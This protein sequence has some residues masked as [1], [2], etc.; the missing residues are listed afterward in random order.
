MKCNSKIMCVDNQ[1]NLTIWLLMLIQ[2]ITNNLSLKTFM[3]VLEKCDP[4]AT[5]HHDFNELENVTIGDENRNPL[6]ST[7]CDFDELEMVP[8]KP[9]HW[10]KQSQIKCNPKTI[11][12][13][14]KIKIKQ[15]LKLRLWLAQ[16]HDLSFNTLNNDVSKTFLMFTK[17]SSH[18]SHK[19]F[20]Y[21]KIPKF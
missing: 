20:S 9:T 11:L 8:I 4:L 16:A 13:M 21:S 2:R 7:H 14:M 19:I 3:P 6:L 15:W 5:A 18:Q 12:P 10:W 17:C 1:K